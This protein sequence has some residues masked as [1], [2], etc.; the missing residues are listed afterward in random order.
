MNNFNIVSYIQKSTALLKSKYILLLVHH[1]KA[2][3]CAVAVIL[4]VALDIEMK[5]SCTKESSLLDYVQKL[6]QYIILV[7]A[8][9]VVNKNSNFRYLMVITV[10]LIIVTLFIEP[11]KE[12]ILNVVHLILSFK[13]STS[14]NLIDVIH[15]V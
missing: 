12:A 7:L 8:T 11:T 13:L 14:I 5:I 2:I 9:V 15:A 1:L 4:C 3:K 6:D 10:L